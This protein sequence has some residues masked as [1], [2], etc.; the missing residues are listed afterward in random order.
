MMTWGQATASPVSCPTFDRAGVYDPTQWLDAGRPLGPTTLL[1]KG[2]HFDIPAGANGGGRGLAGPALQSSEF[3][4]LGP[5]PRSKVE[6]AIR[7]ADRSA[8]MAN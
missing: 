3:R 6:A 8:R 2:L 5:R 1:I 4:T 7:T